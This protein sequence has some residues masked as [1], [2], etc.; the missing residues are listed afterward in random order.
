[1]TFFPSSSPATVGWQPR[2]GAYPDRGAV[3]FHVWAPM[4]RRIELVL[5]PDGANSERRALTPAANGVFTGTFA[6]VSAG[7]LYAYLVDG[8]GPFPDPASRFQPHGVH[9]PSA[10]VDPRAFAWSDDGWRGVALRE[11]VIY[12]LHVGTFSEAGTFAAVTERLPYLAD[13][14]V[15][16]LELMPI[17][18]FPGSRNWGYDGVSLFAPSRAYGAPDDLRR[19][20]NAAHRC[21]LAVMLDVVYNHFGPDGAYAPTF[22]PFYFST[23]HRSPWG[24][25]VNLDGEG[26]QQ[27]REFFIENALHWLHEYHFDGLR[28]DATHGLIDA[29]PRHLV[30]ELAARARASLP[31]RPVLLIAEDERNLATIVRPI[32]EGGWGLDAVWADDFHHQVRRLAAGDRDGYYEDFTG[33]IPDLATTIQQGWFYRGQFSAHQG[34]PRGTDP[35]GVPLDRMVF[36][37]Q[38]HDQI[39]NRPFG[40]RLNDQIE[41]ALFR[42]LSALLLFLPETPLLFM[43]QEWAASTR[44]LFFT[45]HNVDLGRLVTKGRREEFSRFEAF[46]DPVIRNRIPDPQAFSTFAASR[47]VWDERTQPPHAGVLELYRALLRLRRTE[48]ALQ[49]SH[50]FDVVPL[51]ENVLALLRAAGPDALLLLLCTA[52]SCRIDLGQCR[53]VQLNRNWEVVLTTEDPQFLESAVPEQGSGVAITA[54]GVPTVSASR[55]VSAILRGYEPS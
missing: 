16:V 5:R 17:A 31:H 29:S 54:D 52:P 50:R 8:E 7:D 19:L 49:R 36:C 45:D 26:S 6:D 47:L 38:N 14:G 44:F 9:G 24:A 42:A 39:G 48:P 55:P 28:L 43:G 32:E 2:L 33:T 10:I 40:R 3:T 41:P 12:E 30:P 21:G 15:T 13:L 23:R 37:L 22:S 4:R 18:D 53:A 35:S 46:A 1:V 11:A 27:V 34:K 25:A 51:D 20:V